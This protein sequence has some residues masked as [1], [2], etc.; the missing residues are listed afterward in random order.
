MFLLD[1]AVIQLRNIEER[2]QPVPD[3]ISTAVNSRDLP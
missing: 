3:Q 2:R 1:I